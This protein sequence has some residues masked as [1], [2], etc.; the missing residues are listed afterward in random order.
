MDNA[1]V[2]LDGPASRAPEHSFNDDAGEASEDD[3]SDSSTVASGEHPASEITAATCSSRKA[4]D[5]PAASLPTTCT[6][7]LEDLED[8]VAISS[9]A[10]DPVHHLQ[11][12][13]MMQALQGQIELMHEQAAA[14]AKNELQGKVAD[15]DGVLQPVADE[16]GRYQ[17]RN[18]VLDMQN[19]AKDLGREGAMKVCLLYTSP[20]P[21][22]RG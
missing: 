10:V 13:Q 21:R 11:P 4:A 17:M 22:D 14:I 12:V 5:T 16:G 19:I 6:A 7:S 1:P 8:G 15:A 18:I 20:S 3:T 2:Q 9:I